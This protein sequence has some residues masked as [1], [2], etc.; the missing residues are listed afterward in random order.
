[1][2]SD[3]EKR[4]AGINEKTKSSML[5]ELEDATTYKGKSLLSPEEMG[6]LICLLPADY[7]QNLF[8]LRVKEIR[9]EHG[10]FMERLKDFDDGVTAFIK[11]VADALSGEDEI[12]E[13]E[14]ITQVDDLRLYHP[15]MWYKVYKKIAARSLTWAAELVPKDMNRPFLVP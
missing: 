1:M 10:I 3:W 6:E 9:L 11:A 2:S 12:F 14:I 4:F 13:I 8:R 7:F 5:K 15:A